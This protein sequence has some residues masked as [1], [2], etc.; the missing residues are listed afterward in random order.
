MRRD[1]DDSAVHARNGHE[2]PGR[3]AREPPVEHLAGHRALAPRFVEQPEV[4]LA[5][6]GL[7][8]TE[9]VAHFVEVPRAVLNQRRACVPA[10]VSLSAIR[11]QAPES[12]SSNVR[13][14]DGSALCR[15]GWGGPGGEPSPPEIGVTA[16]W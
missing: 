15:W 12:T 4:G 13:G 1:P 9:L 5:V 3:I 8:G 7:V 16:T 11:S 14:G 2:A 6:R 10:T